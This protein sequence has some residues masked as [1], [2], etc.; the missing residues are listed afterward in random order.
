MLKKAHNWLLALLMV[1]GSVLQAANAEQ[2][3][4]NGVTR[5]FFVQ[6]PVSARP[7]AVP[8]VFVLHG[9]GGTARSVKNFGE[10]TGFDALAKREGFIAVYPVAYEE[11]WHDSDR[12]GTKESWN[13]DDV[14]FFRAMIQH[15][16]SRYRIDPQRIYATGISNG[17]A[18]S[19]KLACDA[20]NTFAAIAPVSSFFPKALQATCN[21]SRPVPVLFMVGTNDPLVPWQG[22][23]LHMRK[24]QL[25]QILPAYGTIE[26]WARHNGCQATSNQALPDIDPDD[27]TRISRRDYTQCKQDASVILY[28]VENGGH[29]WPGGKQYLPKFMVGIA[30]QDMQAGAVIWDFFK[31]HALSS[32]SAVDSPSRPRPRPGFQ[33]IDQS[34][35]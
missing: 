4:H 6:A 33:A 15:L 2:I 29:T 8:L 3:L 32:A 5:E 21:P 23:E 27:K 19:F 25:G 22:G 16:S 1:S 14:G 17:G 20:A 11:H 34:I 31:R 35:D 7:Q 24:K 12:E 30:S 9:G 28:T 10:F 26:F 13:I 18:M